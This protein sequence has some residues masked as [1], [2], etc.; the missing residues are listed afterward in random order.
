[1]RELRCA[2]HLRGPTHAL[3]ATEQVHGAARLAGARRTDHSSA[4]IFYFPGLGVKVA[5]R[6]SLQILIAAPCIPAALA[7]VAAVAVMVG[8]EVAHG[9]PPEKEDYDSDDEM[10]AVRGHQLDLGEGHKARQ[11]TRFHRQV[12][13]ESLDSHRDDTPYDHVFGATSQITQLFPW[14]IH[15]DHDSLSYIYDSP[16]APGH[17]GEAASV[18]PAM[19]Q[20]MLVRMRIDAVIQGN[21]PLLED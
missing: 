14:Y 17:P 9:F 18:A 10:E 21:D 4:Y 3:A 11:N 13:S 7:T 19:A 12:F 2:A 16:G 15:A 5:V 8:Y 20:H 6:H 1:M